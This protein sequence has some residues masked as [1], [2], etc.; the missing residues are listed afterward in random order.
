VYFAIILWVGVGMFV[1]FLRGKL[2][3][4]GIC[5]H[6]LLGPFGILLFILTP[7]PPK[8][9]DTAKAEPPP[10]DADKPSG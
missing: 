4:L 7:L 10:D 5:W 2:T 9:G 1:A 8:R 3:L 6:I